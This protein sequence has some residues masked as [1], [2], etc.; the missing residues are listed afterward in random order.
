MLIFN[1]NMLL[2]DIIMLLVDIS[3]SDFNVGIKKAHVNMIILNVNVISYAC[4]GQT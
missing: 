2:V 4:T 3:K 1:L